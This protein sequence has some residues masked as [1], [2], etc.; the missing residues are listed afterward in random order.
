[1]G[2]GAGFASASRLGGNGRHSGGTHGGDLRAR[3]NWDARSCERR[4][5]FSCICSSCG[6]SSGSASPSTSRR[7]FRYDATKS[8]SRSD[9]QKTEAFR[10]LI[11]LAVT[12]I[13]FRYSSF[14]LPLADTKKT[15]SSNLVSSLSSEGGTFR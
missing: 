4:C 15:T 9:S 8:T 7:R 14:S 12:A 3:D 6:A 1:L 2:V 5:A 10:L 13:A 11:R